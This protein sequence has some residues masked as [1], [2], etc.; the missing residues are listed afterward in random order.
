MKCAEKDLTGMVVGRLKDL[1]VSGRMRAGSRLSSEREL[2]EKF[3]VSRITVRRAI[4]SMEENGILKSRMGSGTYVMD[5]EAKNRNKIVSFMS[6][7]DGITLT[8]VQDMALEKGYLLSIY[9]QCRSKWRPEMERIYMEAVKNGR[10]AALLAFCSPIEPK[11]D[12]MLE[13]LEK[14]GVRVIHVDHYSEKL[15]RQNYILSDLKRAGHMAAMRLIMGGYAPIVL[16]DN[17]FE[18]KPPYTALI[19]AGVRDAIEEHGSEK[20]RIIYKNPI[21]ATADKK[22]IS[23]YFSD[24]PKNAGIISLALVFSDGILKNMI[25]TGRKIPED[26]GVIGIKLSGDLLPSSEYDFLDF[27]YSSIYEKALEMAIRPDW[28]GI[29]ELVKPELRLKGSVRKHI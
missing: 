7:T 2:S 11:N 21:D 27:N 28:Q 20:H 25:Q 12:D 10:H 24:I 14:S 6:G 5:K 23:A 26:Y 19:E 9:S 29:R 15:P 18:N 3:K 4:K 16:L 8:K 1:I 13:A 22:E 17:D